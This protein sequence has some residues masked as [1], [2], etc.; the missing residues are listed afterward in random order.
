M[1]N[2]VNLYVKNRFADRR[3]QQIPMA[4]DRRS[5]QDRRSNIRLDDKTKKDIETILRLVPPTRKLWSAFQGFTQ[6]NWIYCV[7]MSGRFS[8]IF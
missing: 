3:T 6:G 4:Y 5:G 2:L 7:C 8:I 1:E